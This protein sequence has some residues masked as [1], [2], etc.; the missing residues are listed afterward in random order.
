MGIGTDT[1]YRLLTV[2]V[3]EAIL[4]VGVSQ[5]SI[6]AL[7]SLTLEGLPGALVFLTL[8]AFGGGLLGARAQRRL[9]AIGRTVDRVAAGDLRAR[10]PIHA[11]G[12]YINRLAA[13]L[14]QALDRL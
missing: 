5:Q 1:Q 14:N 3:L 13:Q 10:V 8:I 7:E 6:D 12:D 2:R 4:T 9:D 11:R